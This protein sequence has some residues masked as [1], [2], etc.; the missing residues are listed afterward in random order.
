MEN[1]K[2]LSESECKL[3]VQIRAVLS[4]FA[5][6]LVLLPS[7]I[8]RYYYTFK[9]E[10]YW[11]RISY[12]GNWQEESGSFFNI[13]AEGSYADF[14]IAIFLFI[15]IGSMVAGICWALVGTNSNKFQRNVPISPKLF[16]RVVA[17]L[18]IASSTISFVGI[19][20][21]YSYVESIRSVTL[22]EFTFSFY[23]TA[24]ILVLGMG[25]G[26]ATVIIP[27]SWVEPLEEGEVKEDEK[28]LEN[29]E[30]SEQMN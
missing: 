22:G 7:V 17:L 28:S 27:G 11:F 1:K 25:V 8:W 21:F 2:K 9:D 3:W 19:L 23:I 10:N 20:Q 4:R 29:E 13:I 16:R 24:V 12:Y 14:P 30:E 6:P 15:L 26:M 18:L 5:I